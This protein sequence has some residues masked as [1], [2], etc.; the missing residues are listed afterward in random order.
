[1]R[2]PSLWVDLG[3]WGW[4]L[5][6]GGRPYLSPPVAIPQSTPHRKPARSHSTSNR[7]FAAVASPHGDPKPACSYSTSQRDFAAVASPH[8]H[9]KPA[10]TTGVSFPKPEPSAPRNDPNPD[11]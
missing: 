11:H 5:G 4:A 9:P 2:R 7:N 6:G 3:P 8:A 10:A 1:M